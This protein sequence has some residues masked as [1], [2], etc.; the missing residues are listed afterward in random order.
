MIKI[1]HFI[2]DTNIGGAGNLLCQQIKGLDNKKFD[3]TVA[4]PRGSALIKKLYSLPCKIIE[5]KYCADISFSVQ[6]VIENYQTI[7]ASHPD[8]VHS[9]GS[10]SSRI[11]ATILR[12]PCRIFTRHCAPPPSKTIKNP[13]I[14]KVVGAT[15]NMLSTSI[16]ATA[17]YAKQNLI[18]L[19]CDAQKITT[20]VNGVA[21]IRHSSELEKTF[22]RAKYGLNNN[23]FVVSYFA[24]LEEIK[25]HKTLLEAAKICQKEYPNFRFFIVGTGSYE[26][27]LKN[28]TQELGIDDMV[29]FTGFCDNVAPIFN[30]T[31]VNV[32]CSFVSETA[33]LS[34]SEGMSIG[35]PCVASDVA[36]NPYMVK[37]EQNGLVFKKHSAQTLANALIRLYCDNELY[38]K[39]SLGALKRY[40]EELNDKIMCQKM[41][42]LYL[43]EYHRINKLQ[44]NKFTTI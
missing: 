6:S 5:L 31:D 36:G 34:L 21:P 14:K 25:G 38:K 11:A 1:L 10:L 42:N 33:S 30:I 4:V 7:K 3:I 17:E 9:H 8:I 26:Q 22:L 19:G 32:N 20:I 2:T 18:D 12:I 24:R 39:C 40:R 43:R 37:N 15:N 28:Y 16:I 29:Y 35:I 41:T 27:N 44:R 13:L 23:D